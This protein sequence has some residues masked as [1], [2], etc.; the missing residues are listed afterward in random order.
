MTSFLTKVK[1][2]RIFEEKINKFAPKT[3]ESIMSANKIF[4]KFCAEKF[5]DRTSDSK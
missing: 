2:N 5:D 3:Q 4:A 1:Q